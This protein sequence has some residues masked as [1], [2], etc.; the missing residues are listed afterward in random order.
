MKVE[1]KEKRKYE[2]SAP[3]Q[4]DNEFKTKMEFNVVSLLKEGYTPRSIY[5]MFQVSRN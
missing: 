3:K 2:Y 4:I 1:P 5:E